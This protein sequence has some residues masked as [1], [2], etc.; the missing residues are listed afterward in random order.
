MQQGAATALYYGERMYEFPLGIVGVAVA[1]A[2]FP[3][4]SRH[5]ARGDRER[6]GA[7]LTLG[8]ADGRY[9]WAYPPAWD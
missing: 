4:L 6:L 1:T 8:P 5:A 9:R 3:L 2:I 7:D